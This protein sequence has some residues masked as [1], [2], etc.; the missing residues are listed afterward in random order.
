MN[1]LVHDMVPRWVLGNVT[2]NARSEV[3]TVS[4]LNTKPSGMLCHVDLQTVTTEST[5][6]QLML[7]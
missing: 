4:L 7:H 5:T 2:M 6:Y 3:L 1:H